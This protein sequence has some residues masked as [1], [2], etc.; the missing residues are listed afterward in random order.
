MSAALAITLP[1]CWTWSPLKFATVFLH[2]GTSPDY[3]EDGTVRAVS[4][5]AI[6]S[7]EMDWT[8]TRLHRHEGDPRKIKGYLSVDDVLVNSTGTGTLGRVGYFAGGPDSMPCMADGH[9][10]VA[11]ADRQT[12]EPRYLYYWLSSSLFYEYIYSALIVGATN[13]IELNRERLAAAPIALPPLD[14]QRRIANFLDAESAKL[15][16]LTRLRAKQV[17]RLQEALRAESVRLTGRDRRNRMEKTTEWPR[18]ALR[19]IVDKVRTGLTPTEF[20]QAREGFD[21]MPWYTPAALDGLLDLGIADRHVSME[22]SS[23]VPKFSAGSILI[24][25]IG[26]SLGKVAPLD[27]E[28]TG[29]QQLT[30]IMASESIDQRFLAWQLF[31][32]YE[33]IREWAQYSRIRILNNEMLKSFH[34]YIPSGNYQRNVRKELD[35]RLVEF[36]EFRDAAQRFSRIASERRQALIT[37]AVTGQVDVTTARGL[38]ERGGIKV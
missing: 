18:V 30:A 13:Q 37:A 31:A 12:V 36:R 10:T 28:A 1:H 7:A 26:E 32:A 11:R 15:D 25:G 21:D 3:S 38:S 34:V 16:Q 9:V 19:R 2:R 6:Q 14:D 8:L 35:Q 22:D 33:E 4:Q 24:V 20:L 27:H 23:Q 29:N 5:A 17:E